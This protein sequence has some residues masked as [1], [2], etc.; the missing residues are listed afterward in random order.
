M[1][2][3][4]VGTVTIPTPASETPL[5]PVATPCA[6]QNGRST[7]TSLP[8]LNPD[9]ARR[10]IVLTN[11]EALFISRRSSGALY[12]GTYDPATDQVATIGLSSYQSEFDWIFPLPQGRA[13]GGI[14]HGD[15]VIYA[16]YDP[17]VRRFGQVVT[18]TLPGYRATSGAQAALLP[19]GEILLVGSEHAW[20]VQTEQ[21]TI[22]LT[23]PKRTSA[24]AILLSLSDGRVMALVGQQFIADYGTLT[25]EAEIYDPQ[26]DDWRAIPPIPGGTSEIIP[27][28]RE[29]PPQGFSVTALS[30]G[31]VLL[32][33]GQRGASE[34]R[35]WV[36]VYEPASNAWSPRAPLPVP[37]AWHRATALNDGQILVTGGQTVGGSAGESSTYLYNPGEDRWRAAGQL[38]IGRRKHGAA[39]LP[40]G[41][42]L[43]LQGM[44]SDTS[45]PLSEIYAPPCW[46]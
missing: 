20:R 4:L 24:A 30:D 22:A 35:S 3:R 44:R 33:G 7:P 43:L 6:S 17:S 45:L 16:E 9:D 14:V 8:L 34:V 41:R 5:P 10:V 28:S 18:L 27:G 42:V 12:G 15:V 1:S 26:A 31:R 39:L 23:G 21:Q 11:G 19:T 38:L 37:L 40:D 2:P 29:R 13:I 36:G 25:T 46:P 32:A